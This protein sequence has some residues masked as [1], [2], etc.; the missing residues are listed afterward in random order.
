MAETAI[1]FSAESIEQ[2]DNSLFFWYHRIHNI[3]RNHLH[4]RLR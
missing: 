4:K 2:L 3:Y 1:L